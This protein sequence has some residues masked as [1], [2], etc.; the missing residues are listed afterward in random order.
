MEEKTAADKAQ[1]EIVRLIAAHKFSP[2]EKLLETTLAKRLGMSRTP[3]R[4]ALGKLASTGFLLKVAGSRGYQI[5]HL[6]PQDIEYVFFMRA[7][8]ESKASMLCAKEAD[9]ELVAK[10]RRINALEEETFRANLKGEYAELNEDFH[11]LVADS[12][13]NPYLAI[14]IKQLYWRSNLYVLFF[15]SFYC[16]DSGYDKGRLSFSEHARVIDAIESGDGKE[17]EA[18][19]KDHIVSSYNSLLFPKK[20]LE[21]I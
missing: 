8:L 4:E 20:P 1:S 21:G 16:L 11:N 13:G 2:G 18:A 5:P 10:L 14:Y 17:A 6:T 19:M 9:K 3:V 12:S 15:M 7:V